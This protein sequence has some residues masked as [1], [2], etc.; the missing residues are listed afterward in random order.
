MATANEAW[1]DAMIRHQVGLMRLAPGISAKVNGLLNESEIDLQQQI[2][3]RYQQGLSTARADALLKSMQT[4]RSESWKNVNKVWAD[5]F[6]EL[7]KTEPEFL[8]ETLRAVSP[9]Q[10][11]VTLPTASRMAA[12][13]KS[14]PFEGLVM[15]DWAQR[16][17]AGDLDRLLRGVKVGLAQGQNVDQISKRLFGTVQMKGTDGLT[18]IT[19]NNADSITRTAV[20]AIANAAKQEFYQE[21]SDILDLE[22]FLATLDA[23]TTLLCASNDNK[24]F[25]LGKG[26]IPPL[27]WRCRSL[28][29]A[30][31]NGEVIGNRPAREF[32]EKQMLGE[33]ADKHGLGKVTDRDQLPK[34]H[35]TAYDTYARGRMRELTGQVPAK[36][37]YD[38]WLRRQSPEFQNEVLGPARAKM[39]REGMKLDKF[40]NREGD[41]LTLDQLRKADQAALN[42][43]PRTPPPPAVSVAPT[44]PPA[45]ATPKVDLDALKARDEALR[46]EQE[47]LRAKREAERVAAAKAEMASRPSKASDIL[48]KSTVID[49]NPAMSQAGIDE[50]LGTVDEAGWTKLLGR[51]NAKLTFK[52]NLKGDVNGRAWFTNGNIEIKMRRLHGPKTDNWS[53]SEAGANQLEQVT[54]TTIHEFGHEVH[55][56]YS[57]TGANS[58][59]AVT[60]YMVDQRIS[61]TFKKRKLIT[62]YAETNHKEYW[63]ESFAKFHYDPDW[64]F[65]TSPEAYEMVVD[66][67]KMRGLPANSLQLKTRWASRPAATP[68]PKEQPKIARWEPPAEPVVRKMPTVEPAVKKTEAGISLTQ[69]YGKKTDAEVFKFLEKKVMDVF[70]AVTMEQLNDYRYLMSL[71]FK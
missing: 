21:N 54:L 30:I 63:A 47:A 55:L 51:S 58:A 52:N 70:Q 60:R 22:V 35:K 25:P 7:A 46:R 32:T 11:E 13:A 34:G 53:A 26:P 49:S 42:V 41:T 8:D 14:T 5:E 24:Q 33:Y 15:K 23:R 61:S 31:I 64:L 48:R 17:A 39:F 2:Q 56:Y 50:V 20:N 4:V 36:L 28:R 18:Q 12:I 67:L 19:R 3:K 1:M 27:H 6:T 65:Q 59:E 38:E 45:P 62:K 66:V 29:L 16:V 9:A 44:P 37:S 10:L 68:V 43:T 40:V 71:G 69:K 57:T